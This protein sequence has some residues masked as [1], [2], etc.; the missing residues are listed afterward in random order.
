[1]LL[2]GEFLLVHHS[3]VGAGNHAIPEVGM[4][5]CLPADDVVFLE[6]PAPEWAPGDD[7]ARE[8]AVDRWL[9]LPTGVED[10]KRGLG[11]WWLLLRPLRLGIP[12]VL[13]EL[14]GMD[15]SMTPRSISKVLKRGSSLTRLTVR[16]VKDRRAN[17]ISRRA[18]GK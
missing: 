1:L 13:V 14:R 6:T 7:A 17:G 11:G 8:P 2:K 10:G 15:V 18:I 5:T 16:T 12:S 4:P 9:L 3:A